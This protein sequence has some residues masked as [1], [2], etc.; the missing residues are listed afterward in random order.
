MQIL[1][2]TNSHI[3]VKIISNPCKHRMLCLY[4]CDNYISCPLI[5]MLLRLSRSNNFLI[6][7]SS[8]WNLKLYIFLLKCD[9]FP[10]THRTILCM[11][12]PF[13]STLW[14]CVLHLHL[15]HAH[16]NILKNDSLPSAFWTLFDFTVLCP[17]S[18][19]CFTYL[20]SLDVDWRFHSLIKVFKGKLEI[21]VFIV[22]IIEILISL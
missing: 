19:A 11:N 17:S 5:R 14:A 6:M 18:M 22:S 2:K 7:L 9:L 12:M 21:Y 20:V 10:F 13:S 3:R 1:L 16:L 8:F 4:N 15:H